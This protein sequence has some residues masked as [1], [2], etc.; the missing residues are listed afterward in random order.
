[1]STRDALKAKVAAEIDRQAG[2]I[3]A[4]SE[5]IMRHPETGF[6]EHGT[7]RRVSG[8]FRAMGVPFREGLADTGVKARLSGRGGRRTVAVLGEL[9]SLL[10]SGHVLADQRTG[11]AHACGHNAQIAS[12]VG[13][14]LG[15]QT[16]MDELDGDVVLFAVPAEECI[17][18]DWRLA[19][20][21]AGALEFVLGKAE[22]IRLGEFDDIDAAVITHTAGGSDGPL[23]TVTGT[24]NGSLIKRVRF[25][26]RASH[27]GV[28]PWAGVNAFK[29]LTLAVAAIDAQRETFREDDH[30]RVS[31]LVTKSGEAV[32]AIP[33]DVQMEMMIRARTV[34]AMDE[35]S[36]KVDRALQ[37]GALAV[38]ADVEI[39]TVGGYLPM[40]PDEPLVDVVDTN[41]RALLGEGKVVRDGG[42]LSGS[43][44]VGDLG[45]IMPVAH[46]MA[47]SGTDAAF[48]SSDYFVSDHVLAA[49]NPAK[50][51]AMTVVDL[52]YDGAAETERVI[53][54]SG[55]KVSR[56][57]Y[58]A[59]RRGLD[60][61]TSFSG[62]A[63]TR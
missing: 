20:R 21:E 36:A 43:T 10:D 59:L 56:E 31:H 41:C 44:D 32:S 15:L 42:H 53:R 63:F 25:R 17:E 54:E 55:P 38:G 5:E 48:H 57:E 3:I 1:M 58:V 19:Q 16:V 2:R 45:Q 9:D 4:L 18:L 52:L 28:A 26:G 60:G 24:A 27:A 49:V 34:A 37:A 6:R 29:A 50:F 35:A 7:A 61:T 39:T 11:A 62:A 46:P 33:A 30:V 40:V 51:M 47:A 8:Q 22:L 13:A 23:A 12:M 14:G